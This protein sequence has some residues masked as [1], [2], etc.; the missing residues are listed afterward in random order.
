MFQWNTLSPS[1][2]P[3]NNPSMTTAQACCMLHTGFPLG[4]L[5]N[6]KDGSEVFLWNAG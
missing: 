2:K 1:S 4:P 6:P 5:F 3:K